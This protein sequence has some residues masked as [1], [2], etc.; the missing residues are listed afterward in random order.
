MQP[1]PPQH[2]LPRKFDGATNRSPLPPT[3]MSDTEELCYICYDA[4]SGDK[5]FCKE[6]PCS[7]KGSIKI[8]TSCLVS[9]RTAGGSASQKCGICRQEFQAG[10][11]GQSRRTAETIEEIGEDY[12]RRVYPVNKEGLVH[13]KMQ[14]YYPSGRL[15][16]TYEYL[17]GEVNG[18]IKTY[19]DT[20]TNGLRQVAR[21]IAGLYEDVATMYFDT[22]EVFREIP[23]KGGQRHGTV[24]EYNRNGQIARMS[25]YV[26][27]QNHGYFLQFYET[28]GKTITA[29][30]LRIC[31][32]HGVPL[33]SESYDEHGRAIEKHTYK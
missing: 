12:Y 7:C 23:Y 32:E 22:G 20:P 33:W 29:A 17:Y 13:G 31:F 18:Y 3:N 1:P 6:S 21:S 25:D 30:K 11:P 9:L 4:A 26:A 28:E 2:L 24:I 8:H 15:H 5:P 14:V 16:G 19:Y 10:T 27:D